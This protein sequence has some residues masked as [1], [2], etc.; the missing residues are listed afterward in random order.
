LGKLQGERYQEIIKSG[1]GGPASDQ[2]QAKS[3]GQGR[4]ARAAA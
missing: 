1:N 4:L 3:A 2:E